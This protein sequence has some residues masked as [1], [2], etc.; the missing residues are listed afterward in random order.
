MQNR[1][2]SKANFRHF[3]QTHSFLVWLLPSHN[4]SHLRNHADETLWLFP[5]LSHERKPLVHS[6]YSH[7][8]FQIAPLQ[9]HFDLLIC[10][11]I[12][13]GTCFMT[14]HRARD[15]HGSSENHFYAFCSLR[16]FASPRQTIHHHTHGPVNLGRHRLFPKVMF[17][18]SDRQ[19]AFKNYYLETQFN[20]AK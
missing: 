14:N 12:L 10:Q 15:G 5:L 16:P 18:I 2:D 8:S 19:Y 1:Q 7:S 3:S 9:V 4:P 20:I 6:H 17:L 13:S 11:A